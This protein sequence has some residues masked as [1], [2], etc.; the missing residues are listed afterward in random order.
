MAELIILA[1]MV[2]GVVLVEVM[3]RVF[4]VDEDPEHLRLPDSWDASKSR[5]IVRFR[6]DAWTLDR[7]SSRD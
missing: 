5:G 1:A 7:H 4:W 2:I 3:P 6:G